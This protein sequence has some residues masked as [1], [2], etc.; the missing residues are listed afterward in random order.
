MMVAWGESNLLDA[1]MS[2]ADRLLIRN[3]IFRAAKTVKES[4]KDQ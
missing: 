1:R 2:R 4:N 3:A